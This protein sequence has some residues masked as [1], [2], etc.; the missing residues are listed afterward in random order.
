M[1][2]ISVRINGEAFS[3]EPGKSILDLAREKGVDIPTLCFHPDVETRNHCGMCVVEIKG[4]GNLRHACATTVQDGME[5][6]TE[7]SRITDEREKNLDL[8]LK[9]HVMECDDCVWMGRCQLLELGKKVKAKPIAAKQKEDQVLQV[10]TVVFDQT[11]CIGCEHCVSVCPT[12]FLEL[13]DRGRVCPSVDGKRDC[14]NCGQC[15][16]HCPVGAIEGVGEFEELEKIFQDGQKTVVVQFAPAIRVSIGDEFGM[17]PEQIATGQ[18][19]AGLKKLG[20]DY[21]FDTAAAADFTTMEESGEVVERVTSGERLPIMTSCCPAWV[22]FVEFNYPEFVPNLATSRSPQ[23]M[24]GGIVKECWSKKNNIN[25]EDIFVVS[26]M[27]CVAKKF[28]IRR[29]ELV[30]DGHR[31]VDMVLTTRELMRLFKKNKIDLKEINEADADDPIGNPS[32]AGVIY[33]A[34]GGVFESALRTVYFR[35]TGE[36]MPDEAVR[37]IRGGEGIRVKE[38]SIDGKTVR[39][40]VVSGLRNA[41][42]VLDELKEQPGLYHALEVMACPGG[43]I[44]GGGQ[45]VPMTREKVK[46]RAKSLYSID[47]TKDIRRAHENSTVRKVYEECFV[48]DEVRKKVLHTRFT[49]RVKSDIQALKNSKET[50]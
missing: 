31:P 36:N 50:L 38:L 5:I 3:V 4:D 18:L 27:P 15:I 24:L 6:T 8:V 34:S 39:V 25:P 28:E 1:E 20:F 10:G 12:G 43:C 29:E 35:M 17:P 45:P 42:K 2:K 13:N 7:S 14:V 49:P 41:K 9:K 47:D 32:G 23:I 44:A 22:K 30:I 48:D 46:E 33:G 26:I 21:V 19:V 16:V 40:C 37:E 11:K